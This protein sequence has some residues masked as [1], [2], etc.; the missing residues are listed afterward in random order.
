MG[1]RNV[2]PVPDVAA[3]SGK[4]LSYRLPASTFTGGKGDVKLTAVQKDGT[5]LPAWLK[6]NPKTGHF[7]GDV[8]ADLAKPI[9][10]RVIAT[11]DVGGQAEAKVRIKPDVKSVGL[12]GKP[13]LS[14]QL[15][16]ANNPA[17]LA[18]SLGDLLRLR[19]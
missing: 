14:A 1:L 18:A 6:F 7:E 16:A 9:D 4:P 15:K 2:R 8:P 19:A 10:L 13:G 12:K 3:N 5:P 11:D 17:G